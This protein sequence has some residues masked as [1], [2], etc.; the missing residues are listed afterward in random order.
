MTATAEAKQGTDTVEAPL[1]YYIDDGTPAASK[2][3]DEI[4]NS[5]SYEGT[6][7]HKTVRIRDARPIR[8]TFKLDV[9]GFELV[10]H[11]TEVKDFF[12][13]DEM[14]NVYYKKTEELIKAASG[15]VRVHVFDHTLRSGD[16]AARTGRP[17]RE[18]VRRVH[19][20][21]TE[22]SGPQRV[23]DLLPDEA[24]ELLKHRFAIIQVWRAVNKPIKSDPLCICDARDLAENHLFPSRRVYPDRVGE[25]Y[26]VTYSPNHEW[27]YFSEMT[28]DEALVF[29]VYDSAT[30]GRA[31]WTAHT[32]FPLPDQDS[33]AFPRESCEMRALAFFEDE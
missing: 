23:R 9:S 6:Y 1:M 2:T 26:V 8:D 20:D 11:P 17:V 27:L 10:D 19:N 14:L 25:T 24:D 22:W 28:R 12:D 7:E 32:S 5:R 13:Q 21:Y 15:A 29:K 33:A 16:E 31:R 30:D 3:G 4:D 18:P